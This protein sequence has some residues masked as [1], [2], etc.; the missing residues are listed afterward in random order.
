[1]TTI[2]NITRIDTATIEGER[3]Y[4]VSFDLAGLSDEERNQFGYT[5]RM[6]GTIPYE[7]VDRKSGRITKVLCLADL[8]YG[9]SIEKAIKRRG[10]AFEAQ[11]TIEKLRALGMN[12]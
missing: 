5:D 9:E 11:R 1:M 4:I 10:D 2:T 7:L 3:F 6:F 8:W 12:I